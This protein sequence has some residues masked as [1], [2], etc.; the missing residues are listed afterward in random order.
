LI[1]RDVFNWPVATD[2]NGLTLM[3]IAYEEP[4]VKEG[5][6]RR[7]PPPRRAARFGLLDLKQWDKRRRCLSR[8][9]AKAL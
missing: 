4:P 1:G 9:R 6:I 8:Y 7:P 2:A 3:A 5:K